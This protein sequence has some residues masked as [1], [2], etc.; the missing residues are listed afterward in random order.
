MRSSSALLASGL[1]LLAGALPLRAQETATLQGRVTSESGEGVASARALLRGR[2]LAEARTATADARGRFEIRDVPPGEYVLVVRAYG[3]RSRRLSP[4]PVAAGETRSVEVVLVRNPVKLERLDVVTATREL[5]PLSEIAASVTVLDREEIESQLAVT[6]DIGEILSQSVPGMAPATETVS[7]FG[8]TLR[9]RNLQVLVDGVPV[10]T[11]L[12]NGQRGLHAVDPAAIERIEVIRGS[13]A[14]YG[15]G[16]TGGVVNVITRPPG[17]GSARITSELRLSLPATDLG[18]DA[19]IRTA[20]RASGSAGEL[21]YT[22]SGA[23]EKTS[24]RY[25]AQGDPIPADPQAQGGVADALGTDLFG[26]AALPAGEHGE[27][28]FTAQYYRF[29]QGERELVT[30]PGVVGE[31]KAT[32][33]PGDPRSEDVGNENLFLG[34]RYRNRDVLGGRLEAQLYYGDHLARFPYSGFFDA[35]SRVVSEKLGGRFQAAVP[36]GLTPG[37]S[38]TWGMDYLRDETA[39]PLSDGRFF[40]PP[41]T[42]SSIG[43]FAHLEL[44]LGDR[45]LVRGGVRHEEIWLSVED[46]TTIEEM[47]GNAVEGG[48]LRYD[49]TVF[50]AGAVLGVGAG[51]DLF[52]NFSQGFSVAEV[53]R[54]LRGTSA[55]SVEA[56][57]PEPKR[58]DQYE[59]GLRG[60]FDRAHF[61]LSAYLN[62]SELGSTFGPDLRIDRAPQEIR[63]LEARVGLLPTDSWKTGGSLTLIEGEHD[64][65][66]D[67]EVDDP[68]PGFQIPPTR[69][70]AYLENRTLPGWMNRIQVSHV[71]SRDEFPDDAGFG[72]GEVRAYTTFD[73]TSRVELRRGSLRLGVRNLLNE[74]YFPAVSQWYNFGFAYAA[75]QGRTVSLA[76]ELPW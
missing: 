46:F 24:R 50:H 22:V 3:Y 17:E 7:D 34:T 65:D 2:A 13:S 15:Y 31:Q 74:F 38:L 67:G 9:G 33:E 51:V 53:G 12:R 14:A 70:T 37:S 52:A 75:G 60:T 26:T 71:G 4:V 47:G 41:M 10:T 6:T 61:S 1:L 21:R 18:A 29:V 55:E 44:P 40:A 76:Y 57:S 56:L 16:G 8:Q 59:A 5:S 54:E 39:Q 48:D 19:G 58:T 72:R 30:V 20:H 27:L 35:Q 66:D 36:V 23:A 32:V 62:E 25:D 63:G 28:A 42:Q 11:P 45:L 49:A 64:A 68:M 69:I 73:L 43:P